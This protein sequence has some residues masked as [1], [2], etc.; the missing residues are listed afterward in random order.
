MIELILGKSHTCAR[1]ATKASLTET[2]Q[3]WRVIRDLSENRHSCS[4][5][6]IELILGKTHTCAR[7]A[8]KASDIETIQKWCVL[9]ALSEN[10]QKQKSGRTSLPG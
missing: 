10:R 7:V 8:T 6:L 2:S 1:V 3:K 5:Y 4:K 9:R